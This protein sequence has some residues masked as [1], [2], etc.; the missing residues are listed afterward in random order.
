M[1]ERWQSQKGMILFGIVSGI[2]VSLAFV[3]PY[4]EE[5]TLA[6]VVLQLSGA[7]GAFELGCSLSELVRFMLCTVPNMLVMML[8]GSQMYRQFCTASVYV[9]SRYPNRLFWYLRSLLQ[10]FA[11]VCFFELTFVLSVVLAV[12]PRCRILFDPSGA[13]LLGFHV[14]LYAGWIF[15]WTLLT[16]LLAIRLGSS[17]SFMTVMSIQAV[18]TALLALVGVLEKKEVPE[19]AVKLF[20]RLNPVAH[21]VLSWHRGMLFEKE[22]AHRR[23][24]WLSPAASMMLFVLLDAVVILAG[25]VMICRYD[26]LMGDREAEE[27]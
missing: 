26:L 21:T 25:G 12:M 4:E 8:L 1:V 5:I 18:C 19:A 27:E 10:L 9:F 16:N 15:G 20:V 13:C 24:G 6:R 17:R 22:L 2:L 3:R 14:L 23:Y 11:N 7:R